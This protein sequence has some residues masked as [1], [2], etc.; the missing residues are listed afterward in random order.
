MLDLLQYS[1]DG[2]FEISGVKGGPD[3]PGRD[4]KGPY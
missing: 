4:L 2:A 3:S 1:V